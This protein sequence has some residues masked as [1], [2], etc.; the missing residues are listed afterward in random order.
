[1][2]LDARQ[3]RVAQSAVLTDAV[4][5]LQGSTKELSRLAGWLEQFC[6][7]Q[8]LDGDI[9][10]RLNLTLEELL[11]NAIRH[12]GC[13][14]MP[15]AASIG[16]RRDGGD[17]MVDYSDAGRP[18][19][20]DEAPLPDLAAPLMERKS[21]GLGLHFIRQMTREFEYHRVD[22]RNRITMRFAI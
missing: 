8:G 15:D 14:G 19:D 4:L 17:L 7:E 11:T 22:D 13:E 3:I 2:L 18:F 5:T 16:L 20:P 9:E 10:F 1:L 6:R 21:G 12:G